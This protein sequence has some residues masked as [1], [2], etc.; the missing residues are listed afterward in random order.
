[1]TSQVKRCLY[2]LFL[3]GCQKCVNCRRSHRMIIVYSCGCKVIMNKEPIDLPCE[4]HQ[5]TQNVK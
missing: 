2:P 5:N 1:M 3:N 4:Q